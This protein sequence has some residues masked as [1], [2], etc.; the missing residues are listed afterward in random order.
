MAE[1]PAYVG[2]IF[3]NSCIVPTGEQSVY[4][5]QHLHPHRSL[6]E[7]HGTGTQTAHSHG[8][9]KGRRDCRVYHPVHN[10]L[11]DIPAQWCVA[12]G[13]CLAIKV[14]DQHTAVVPYLIYA[15][16][17]NQ[18]EKRERVFG[19]QGLVVEVREENSVHKGGGSQ[20]TPADMR[21]EGC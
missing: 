1:N 19:I 11:R 14:I 15:L 8:L 16:I 17:H 21:P 10:L 9:H 5:H 3:Q 12:G 4:H 13:V 6:E 7:S 2:E 18:A 20:L